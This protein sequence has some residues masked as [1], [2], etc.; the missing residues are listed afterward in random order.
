MSKERGHTIVALSDGP[1]SPLAMAADFSFTLAAHSASPFDSH[2][3]TLALLELLV[4]GVAERIRDLAAP[5]LEQAEAAW[6]AAG[7]LTDR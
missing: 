2:T 5:R 4:A 3:A 1:L 7:S 6:A